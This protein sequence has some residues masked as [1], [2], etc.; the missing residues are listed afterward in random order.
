VSFLVVWSRSSAVAQLLFVRRL[1]LAVFK[2]SRI[3][4]SISYSAVLTAIAVHC[5]VAIY[6]E[7]VEVPPAGVAVAVFFLCHFHVFMSPNTALEATPHSR[8]GLAVK[9]SGYLTRW[10]RGASAFVR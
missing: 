8:C 9:V 6:S 10:V 7:I 3:S 4:V 2:I 1:E 5:S